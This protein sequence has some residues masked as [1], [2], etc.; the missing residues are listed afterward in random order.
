MSLLRSRGHPIPGICRVKSTPTQCEIIS[1]KSAEILTADMG[2]LIND[3]HPRLSV[4]NTLAPC[5]HRNGSTSMG[6][7]ETVVGEY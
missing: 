6:S 1:I 4:N 3:V 2:T 7:S 5:C